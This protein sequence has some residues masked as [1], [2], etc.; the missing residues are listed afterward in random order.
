M[1]MMDTKLDAT[2][3]DDFL[4]ELDPVLQKTARLV[5]DLERVDFVDST[6]CSTLLKTVAL[7]RGQK[8]DLK[9]CASRPRIHDT[10]TLVGLHRT[11]DLFATVAEGVAAYAAGNE[12]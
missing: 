3:Q 7:V 6:G 11:C 10:F 12:R 1:T 9:I 4:R 2:N 8:G 5:L